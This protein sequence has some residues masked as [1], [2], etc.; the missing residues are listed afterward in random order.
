MDDE[1]MRSLSELGLN[2][3]QSKVYVALLRHGPCTATEICKYAKVPQNRVYSVLDELELKGFVLSIPSKPRNFKAVDPK[4]A[5]GLVIR[6]KMNR[7]SD[8]KDVLDRVA[9][10][11]GEDDFDE[12]KDQFW[13]IRGETAWD[14][15]QKSIIKTK[16]NLRSIHLSF[17]IYR[18]YNQ[19]GNP[20]AIYKDAVDRGVDIKSIV[21]LKKETQDIA[22][23]VRELAEL[24][25]LSFE[26]IRF[27]IMDEDE[28]F[29]VL[30]PHRQFSDVPTRK[31]DYWMLWSINKDFIREMISMFDFVWDNSQTYEDRKNFFKNGVTP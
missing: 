18:L 26:T 22:K 9:Q 15:M 6:S 27:V 16:K 14:K 17:S 29:L 20:L 8:A 21:P 30:C 5:T 1:S 4:I 7:L 24:R 23:K 10:M 25:H 31:R 11:R 13:I 28:I 12:T 19:D 2:E 3:Y